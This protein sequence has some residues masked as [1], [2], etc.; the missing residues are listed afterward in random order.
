M[1]DLEIA[2]QRLKNKELNLVF[3]KN[4]ELVFETKKEGLAGFLQAIEECNGALAATSVADKVIGKAAAFLC[5]YSKV[6]A[7]FA[8]TLSQSGREILNTGNN[9]I[10]FEK[11]TSTILNLKKTDQCPF[12]KLVEN[13][14][15]PET[16]YK[17]IKRFCH[18]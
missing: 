9:Y 10:E 4:S 3:I 16:A 7:A 1:D 18:S 8:I 15:E 11:L 12:E 2:K 13:I 6:K 5:I 17:E 14:T